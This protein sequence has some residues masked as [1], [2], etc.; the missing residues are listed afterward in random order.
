[1]GRTK[2]TEN[3]CSS[4]TR[5]NGSSRVFETALNAHRK[6]KLYSYVVEH[7]TGDA[8]N[9]YFGI[10]TL[11]ICKYRDSPGKPKNIVELAGKGDWVVGTGG[12]DCRKSAGHGKV[13]YAMK[14]TDKMT[15]QEY[16]TSADFACKKLRPNGDY[17]YGDNV[18]PRTEFDMHERFVLVS[19]HFYYFGRSAISIPKKRFPGLEKKGQGFKSRFDEA[20]I[21]SFVKWI[22]N[23]VGRGPGKH[24]EPSL[25]LT[26]R[27][28]MKCNPC[29]KQMQP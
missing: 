28:Q 18:E 9:P 15:L 10:C 6:P 14:V 1:M 19:E 16:F 7:D 11:C 8:P 13:V 2:N 20:Y 4:A 26:V 17:R 22:E 21:A 24:G 23:E 25:R 3:R 12:V 27:N 5:Y 29:P